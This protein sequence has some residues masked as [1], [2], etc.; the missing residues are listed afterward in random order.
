M[1]VDINKPGNEIS[2]VASKE[3]LSIGCNSAEQREQEASSQQSKQNT[4]ATVV[5][6]EA[7]SSSTPP[8]EKTSKRCY[9]DGC[10]KKLGLTAVQ[11]RCG[12]R[13]CALHVLD[14]NCTFDYKAM[15][16]QKLVSENPTVRSAKIVGI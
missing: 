3:K 10:R 15:Q 4:K 8:A 6:S 5:S 14:H 11:C 16:K 13:F 2:S 7:S 9:K 1:N 12:H